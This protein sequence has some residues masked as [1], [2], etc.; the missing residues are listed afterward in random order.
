MYYSRGSK[1]SAMVRFLLAFVLS[2][3]FLRHPTSALQLLL[4]FGGERC[5]S[6]DFESGTIAQADFHATNR[7]GTQNVEIEVRNERLWRIALRHSVGHEKFSFRVPEKHFRGSSVH[8][9]FF[10]VRHVSRKRVYPQNA[11]SI[12]TFHVGQRSRSQDDRTRAE[13]ITRMA[14][15]RRASH[16]I[17]AVQKELDRLI[18]DFDLLGEYEGRVSEEFD[19]MFNSVIRTSVLAC[20]AIVLIGMMQAEA[21]KSAVSRKKNV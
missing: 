11:E 18:T 6:E 13:R 14:D 17:A 16:R 3:L 7:N 5:F 4:P 20:V 21:Y 12:V 8:R 1:T 9:Y 15:A 10:C 2:F 19:A